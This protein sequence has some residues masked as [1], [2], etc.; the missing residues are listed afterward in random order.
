MA[1]VRMNAIL[2][3]TFAGLGGIYH[4]NPDS[5]DPAARYPVV[6]EEDVAQ[7][8]SRGL[9][10][11]LSD[12]ALRA[13]KLKEDPT[14]FES[15]WERAMANQLEAEEEAGVPESISVGTTALNHITEVAF[16]AGDKA[17]AGV[18]ATD[19]SPEQSRISQ[20]DQ[21]GAQEDGT[22]QPAPKQ[23]DKSGSVYDPEAERIAGLNVADLGAAAQGST[24]AGL[25]AQV[26]EIENAKAN[27]RVTAVNSL[28]VRLGELADAD[29]DAPPVS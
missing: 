6:E 22:P 24:D 17:Y 1:K 25:L 15:L 20:A 21:G 12:K 14:S 9:G 11:E 28:T 27:P 7:A 10:E 26:L 19:L 23:S 18:G 8:I 5:K 2:F 3:G 16:P 13:F 29:P 4:F